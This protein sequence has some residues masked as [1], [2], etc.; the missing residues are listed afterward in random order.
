[1]LYVDVIK[2]RESLKIVHG[3]C[4]VC[5]HSATEQLLSQVKGQA[6]LAPLTSCRFGLVPCKRPGRG[7]PHSG[8]H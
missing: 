4:A 2:A 5:C 7:C 1:M 8:N 3:R 6:G